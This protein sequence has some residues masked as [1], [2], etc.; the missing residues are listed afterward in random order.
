MQRIVATIEDELPEPKGSLIAGNFLAFAGAAICRVVATHMTYRLVTR[1]RGGLISLMLAKNLRLEVAEA[2]KNAVVTLMSTD[3][4]SLVDGLPSC[5]EIPFIFLEAG[6]GMYL[7][8]KLVRQSCFVI[9]FP[10]LFATVFGVV[11]GRYLT[12]YQRRWFESV[13]SRVTS[14]SNTLSHIQALK[15]LGLGP[16]S[17]EYLQH[18]RVIEIQNAKQYRRIQVVLIMFSTLFDLLCPLLVVAAGLFWGAFGQTLSPQLVY[19]TVAVV[20]LVQ[21]PL[22]SLFRSYPLAMNTLGCFKRIREFLCKEEHHDPRVLLGPRSRSITRKWPTRSGEWV[23]Q[24][25][26]VIQVPSRVVHFENAS[27]APIGSITPVL[28]EV[29]LSLAP[30][31]ITGVYGSTG[32]GK[33]T[34]MHSVLGEVEVLDGVVYVNDVP[35]AYVGQ[36]PY[37]PNASLRDCIVGCCEWDAAWFNTVVTQ[38]KLL[39]DI[40]RLPGGDSYIVGSNGVGLSGGQRQRVS[41]ARAVYARARCVILDDAFSAL[42]RKTAKTILNNLCG[43]NGLFKGSKTTVLLA[44]Y[45]PESLDLVSDI[46][47]LDG[48]G[49]LRHASGSGSPKLRAHILSLLRQ[50]SDTALDNSN[51]DGT[52]PAP[53]PSA[54]SS[55]Q[56]VEGLDRRS[57]KR[58]LYWFWI[59]AAGILGCCSWIL[60]IL[61]TSILDSFPRIFLKLWMDHAPSSRYWFIGY[62][63]LPFV[64]TIVAAASLL[65]LFTGICPTAAV[66]LHRELI[67]TVTGSTLGF[68]SITDAGSLLNKFSLDMDILTKRI[69]PALHNTMYYF[70]GSV[71]KLG[72]I[73]SGATY[74]LISLPFIFA[75]LFF[76]QRYYLRT[77]RQLRHLELE[78]Q[79]PLV[80]SVREA[81][82]G[83]I[84]IRGFG[85][86]EQILERTLHFLDESQKP[87][88]LLYSSQQ[89]LA[90]IIDLL[91]ALLALVLSIL[92]LYVAHGRTANSTGVAF[93]AIIV[94]G[95]GLNELVIQW[96]SLELTIGALERVHDFVKNTPL[97]SDARASELPDNWP[98]SGE[99]TVT[100]LTARYR[101]GNTIQAPVLRNVSLKIEAGKRVGVTG[102]S[103]SGKSSFLYS[104]LGFLDYNGKIM[105]DGIDIA[106]A[107]RD[108]L[109]ARIITISQ[110]QVE[111]DGTVRENLLPFDTKWDP[112]ALAAEK[113]AEEVANKE[114]IIRETLVRLQIWDKVEEKG[115]LDTL[116]K[117]IGYSYGEKQLLCIARAVV[118]RRL[119]GFNLLLVDEATGSVDYQRDQIVQEMMQ[120]YFKGC[121]I[122]VIAHREESIAGSNI[123]VEMA[124]GCMKKPDDQ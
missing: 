2:R 60:L 57:A 118:R 16:K 88:Y 6:V 107:P 46:V 25:R 90:L 23:T 54:P 41:I 4:D 81:S 51:G 56:R 43:R 87:T 52:H 93:L 47:F 40:S 3:F 15:V 114:R 101:S 22:A 64:V 49:H 61:M 21:T 104:L 91:V 99:I 31:S 84:Y 30:G 124:D 77:S 94:L 96:T 85:W 83:L 65:L 110:D 62:A 9:L 8:A 58:S 18:L 116:L 7:L 1:V 92:T 10:L 34:F 14:T 111:L 98:S 86:D 5:V 29:D 13:E 28:K 38:C 17:A 100:G 75:A 105:I 11:F 67:F 97:E 55:V 42:D 112:D 68:L 70:G 19:P 53:Q 113:I 122:L 50:E 102:R 121:T 44:S 72:I 109:R 36:E 26:D 45:L 115:G 95:E 80:T 20:S 123:T 69:P 106:T 120:E 82:D 48:S 76:L 59:T 27:L 89:L 66:E 32:S 71:A 103:G 73:F 78:S 74:M 108:E 24:T 119:T 39:E 35:I 12:G 79:A 33:T 37:L 117:D 63:V